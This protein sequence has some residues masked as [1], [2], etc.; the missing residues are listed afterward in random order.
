MK[1]TIEDK[2]NDETDVIEQKNLEFLKKKTK[3][4]KNSIEDKINDESDVIEQKNL[5]S[6]I[7]ES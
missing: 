5:R 1:N 3:L 4:L 7:I 2:I 6:S